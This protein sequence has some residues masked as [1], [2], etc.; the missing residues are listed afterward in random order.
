[1]GCRHAKLLGRHMEL[2]FIEYFV[3]I[4]SSFDSVYSYPAS[5]LFLCGSLLSCYDAFLSDI[6]SICGLSMSVCFFLYI[7]IPP[8]PWYH[9]ALPLQLCCYFWVLCMVWIS[10]GSHAKRKIWPLFRAVLCESSQVLLTR[11]PK[12]GCFVFDIPKLFLNFNVLM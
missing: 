9:I 6:R 4:D 3:F 11:T 1:M 12:F 5:C 7:Y 2:F 10:W 8:P